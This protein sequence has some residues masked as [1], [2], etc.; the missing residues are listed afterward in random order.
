MDYKPENEEIMEIPAE[1]IAGM[2]GKASPDKWMT[3]VLTAQIKPTK[4][5]K[6]PFAKDDTYILYPRDILNKT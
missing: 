2:F 6:S 1:H 3:D 5:G 4:T